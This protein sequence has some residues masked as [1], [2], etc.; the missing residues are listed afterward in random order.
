MNTRKH[1]SW[2]MNFSKQ[3]GGSHLMLWGPIAHSTSKVHP[4]VTMGCPWAYYLISLCL[5][6][7]FSEIRLTSFKR[8]RQWGKSLVQSKHSVCDSSCCYWGRHL[9]RKRAECLWLS[10]VL[11]SWIPVGCTNL[12]SQ[13]LYELLFPTSSLGL[14]ISS[15]AFSSFQKQVDGRRKWE[16][17]RIGVLVMSHQKDQE[18]S[19]KKRNQWEV[20][21]SGRKWVLLDGK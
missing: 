15:G 16:K 1:C 11:P 3:F 6:F 8:Q 14:G 20:W 21:E 2:G 7:L 19:T 5:S 12:H 17:G 10:L 9:R 4:K 18:T 13:A